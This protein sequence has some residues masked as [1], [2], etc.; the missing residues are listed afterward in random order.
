MN[1]VQQKISC[2]YIIGVS[3]EVSAKRKQQT[4]KVTAT[5]DL[6][7]QAQADGIA[8]AKATEKMDGTCCLIDVFEGQPWL[9]ARHD[10]KPN[11]AGEKRF[12]QYKKNRQKSEDSADSCF[13]WNF[14]KDFKEVPPNWVPASRLEMVNGFI[15][16]DKL[17]HTPGWVP[18]EVKSRQHCWHLSAVSLEDGLAL[19]LRESDGDKEELVLRSEP[20]SNL[21]GQTCELVGSNINGNPYGIGSKK[22]PLH[23]LVPHGSLAVTCPS[24][25]DHDATV[26]WFSSGTV[27]AGVEGVVWHCSNGE[28]YKL[29]R[30]HLN[31]QWPVVESRLCRRPVKVAVEI[32]SASG[33]EDNDDDDETAQQADV[34]TKLFSLNGQVFDSLQ[35]LC[36]ALFPPSQPAEGL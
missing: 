35:H 2:V 5:K 7:A 33:G 30:H 14:E 12:A 36:T 8:T 28:L 31:L 11:K 9:W 4:Y 1:P 15:M 25:V 29:H 3:D 24:P 13:S 23:F 27:D 20:M 34:F 17:G 21:V 32:V 18:V 16:P 22:N 10:R 19:V 26:A 6:H